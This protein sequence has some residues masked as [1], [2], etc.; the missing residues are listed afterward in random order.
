MPGSAGVLRSGQEA[1]PLDRHQRA[2]LDRLLQLPQDMLSHLAYVCMLPQ[3]VLHYKIKDNI[4]ASIFHGKE[5]SSLCS[6]TNVPV[7]DVAGSHTWLDLL[8]KANNTG[9]RQKGKSSYI[10]TAA[11]DQ[12][13]LF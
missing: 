7:T 9:T 6:S 10:T 4:L 13:R 1:P 3:H 11:K 8:C 12:T 5:I 2:S